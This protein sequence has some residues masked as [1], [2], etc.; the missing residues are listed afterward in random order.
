[1]R[2]RTGAEK[3]QKDIKNE[4]RSYQY[5]MDTLDQETDGWEEARTIYGE[6]REELDKAIEMC[7]D[8]RNFEVN[9]RN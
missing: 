4:M 2:F 9:C 3:S 1:M 7:I 5:N 8:F 6:Y